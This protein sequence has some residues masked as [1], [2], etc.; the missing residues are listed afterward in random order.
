MPFDSCDLE[1]LD[2]LAQGGELVEPLD[3]CY[4]ILGILH[5]ERLK[6]GLDIPFKF[7]K[8]SVGRNTSRSTKSC[9]VNGFGIYF[10]N[11]LKWPLLIDRGILQYFQ[12]I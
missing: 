2:R 11:R 10:Q 12:Q 4:L 1:A 9:S 5:A 3:I 8:A 7:F 6:Y